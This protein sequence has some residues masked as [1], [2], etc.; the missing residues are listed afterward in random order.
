MGIRL[1]ISCR[2][3]VAAIEF[4]LLAPVYLFLLLCIVAYGIYFG[5]SHAVQQISADAARVAVGG[6]SNQER[7]KLATNYVQRFAGKYA[8]IDASR[9][10]LSF[11]DEFQP[12]PYFVVKVS[13]D[14]RQLPIWR[15]LTYLPL[16]STTIEKQSV[17]RVGGI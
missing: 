4:A 16:P 15:M 3:G 1:L 6:L 10:S 17:I 5:A 8:F 9:L 13:F 11:R 7:V 12:D 2:R 14:A